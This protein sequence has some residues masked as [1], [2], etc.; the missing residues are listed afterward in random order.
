M[1]EETKTYFLTVEWCNV[2]HRGIFC[3]TSGQA[4]PSVGEAHTSLDMQQI[5]GP[6][7]VILSPT[8][9]AMT[10]EE[11][12]EYTRFIPLAEYTNQFGVAIKPPVEG[13]DTC[14]DPQPQI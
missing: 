11:V 1:A 2:G 13:E 6:L 8:S 7:W 9:V 14:Q 12:A 4:F 3:A 10:P 5:L